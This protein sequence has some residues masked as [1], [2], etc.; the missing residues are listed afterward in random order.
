M[1][2]MESYYKGT[3]ALLNL[4]L[5]MELLYASRGFTNFQAVTYSYYKAQ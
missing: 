1:I 4:H 2:G 5:L 3:F